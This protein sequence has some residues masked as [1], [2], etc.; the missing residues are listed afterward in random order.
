MRELRAGADVLTLVAPFGV[1]FWDAVSGA[2]VGSGLQVTVYPSGRPA[3]QTQAQP[4]RS[5]VYV[6][7]RLPGLHPADAAAILAS[8]PLAS[9]PHS[10]YY[11]VEVVDLAGRFLPA[12]FEAPM[13]RLGLL[14]LPGCEPEPPAPPSVALFSA[15]ARPAPGAAAVVRAELYDIAHRQP[16]A[17]AILEA[18]SGGRRLGRGMADRKGR[19]LLLLAHPDLP[20]GGFA[21]PGSPVGSPPG[22]A[23]GP[24]T[25]QSWLIELRA[26]YARIDPPP[27]LPDLCPTPPRPA[28]ALLASESPYA[29][30][31]GLRLTYGQELTVVTGPDGGLLLDSASSP[32]LL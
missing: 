19:V 20:R 21:S 2:V 13:P 7:A 1:R 18:W 12:R 26:S 3:L 31:G 17:W 15:P 32:P 8:P 10:R 28:V 11:V 30:L 29:P 22:L 24:L 4:N 14:T 16:A 6:V 27:R 23:G 5:G 9:P 25:S